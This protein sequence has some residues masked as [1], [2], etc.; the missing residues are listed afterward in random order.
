E[1]VIENFPNLQKINVSSFRQEELDV[2]EVSRQQLQKVNSEET[3]QLP[4]AKTGVLDCSEYKDLRYIFISNSVDSSKLEI[5]GGS[6]YYGEEKTKIIPCQSAQTY[7]Q[8]NYPPNGTCQ[9]KNESYDNL[10]TTDNIDNF[11]KTRA[12]ITKL[13]IKEKGLEGNCDLTDFKNLERL[14]CSTNCLTNLN[15]TNCQQLKKIECY[16]NQLTTLDLSNCQQL[17]KL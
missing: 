12:E 11:G 8:Q 15:L 2:D 13:D 17:E 16:D 6:Y 14:Y 9:R 1:L 5:K 3:N 10:N 4:K 7:L